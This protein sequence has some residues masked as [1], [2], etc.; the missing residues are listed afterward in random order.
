MHF[1]AGEQQ[2][3]TTRR[4]YARVTIPWDRDVVDASFANE[5]RGPTIQKIH[6]FGLGACQTKMYQVISEWAQMRVI[7]ANIMRKN[8]V[9]MEED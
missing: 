6:R 3:A 7:S 5:G 4:S 9:Y 1:P 8:F 2:W